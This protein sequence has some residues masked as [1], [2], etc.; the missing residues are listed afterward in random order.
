MFLLPFFLLSF[1]LD[2][3]LLHSQE[4]ELVCLFNTLLLNTADGDEEADEEHECHDC[5]NEYKMRQIGRNPEVVTGHHSRGANPANVIQVP[6]DS[7]CCQHTAIN[8]FLADAEDRDE[9]Y[10]RDER[11]EET[12]P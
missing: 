5:E 3:L 8:H 6:E 9:S 4:Q 2:F 10:N 11:L 7:D 12:I 1:L